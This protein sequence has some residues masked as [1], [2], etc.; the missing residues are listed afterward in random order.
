VENAVAGRIPWL[1][2]GS[3][4]LTG[5]TSVGLKDVEGADGR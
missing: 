4:D 5:S 3:A 2:A 1:L